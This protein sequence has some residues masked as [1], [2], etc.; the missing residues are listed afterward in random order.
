M[1]ESSADPHTVV[2]TK[3]A[4][5][6]SFD[7]RHLCDLNSDHFSIQVLDSTSEDKW[8]RGVF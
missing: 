1:S 3:N 2:L 8:T 7:C 5:G 6:K 4:T